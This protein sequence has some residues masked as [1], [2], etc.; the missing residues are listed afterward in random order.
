MHDRV[1]LLLVGDGQAFEEIRACFQPLIE[2]NH[3]VM[4]GT[5]AD[6]D[7]LNAIAD[8]FVFP[9][10]HE[11]LPFSLLEAMNAGRAIVATAVG[12][13]VEVVIDG[14]TGIL[15]PARDTTA[16]VKAILRLATDGELR[17][18][19]GKAG[20]NR[21]AAHFSAEAVIRKTDALYQ[22][23]L[24]EAKMVAGA[25]TSFSVNAGQARRIPLES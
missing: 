3:V 4:T 11:N 1:K 24:P 10:F 12:G 9:S 13:N 5:R 19:M 22:S 17:Q 25:T 2:S 8:I 21:V 16:L 23:L 18:R 15:V 20:R 6:I 14:E 7:D